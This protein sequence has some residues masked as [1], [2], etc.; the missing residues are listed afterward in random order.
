[1]KAT[2]IEGIQIIVACLTEKTTTQPYQEGVT[3]DK[4]HYMNLIL[5]LHVVGYI[6]VSMCLAVEQIISN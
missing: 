1:M 5:S 3:L 2:V 4:T 6:V